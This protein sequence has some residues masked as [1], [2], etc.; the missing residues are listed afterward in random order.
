MGRKRRAEKVLG[1]DEEKKENLGR[2][3]ESRSSKSRIRESLLIIT[4][5]RL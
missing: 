3:G 5:G 4:R 1:E 2:R